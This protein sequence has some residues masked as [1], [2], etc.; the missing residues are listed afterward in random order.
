MVVVLPAPLGPRNPKISP[1][2]TSKEMPRT[3][4]TILW[5]FSPQ[6]TF[7]ACRSSHVG[8]APG[9]LGPCG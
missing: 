9:A 5:I 3:A 1:A 7:P 4:S 8:G 6:A 2:F